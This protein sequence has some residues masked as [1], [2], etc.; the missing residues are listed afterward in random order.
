MEL[1]FAVY[2]ARGLLLCLGLAVYLVYKVWVYRR[3]SAFK[4]PF[5]SGW[6]EAWSSVTTVSNIAHLKHKEV[7]GKYGTQRPHSYLDGSVQIDKPFR[8]NLSN[9]SERL[10]Y[11]L[12][13]ARHSHERGPF[14]I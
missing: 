9:R 3:L 7:C 13:G 4:G 14:S 10:G 8:V 1:L 6:S 11:Q 2:E 12:P 5:S